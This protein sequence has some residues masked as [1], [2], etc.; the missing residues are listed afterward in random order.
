MIVCIQELELKVKRMTDN[1]MF[2]L[3]PARRQE[4]GKGWQVIGKVRLSVVFCFCT[5]NWYIEFM[6]RMVVDFYWHDKNKLYLPEYC[7]TTP[8]T[9]VSFQE[10]N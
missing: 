3:H 4:T 2:Q 6:A 1:K 10:G 7:N 8:G 5:N 9:T